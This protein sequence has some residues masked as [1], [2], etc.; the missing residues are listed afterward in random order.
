MKKLMTVMCVASAFAFSLT[1][2]NKGG[3]DSSKATLSNSADSAAYALG[4]T[5]GSGLKMNFEN[6]PEEVDIDMFLKGFNEGMK[7]KMED[8]YI[9]GAQVGSQFKSGL[10]KFPGGKLDYAL[11][12]KGLVH[13]LKDADV[14]MT[15]EEANEF[16]SAYVQK[17]E[18][19]EVADLVK[20]DEEYIEKLKADPEVKV[21]ESGLMYKITELGDGEKP[22][23]E[24]T[25]VCHYEGSQVNGEVFDSSYERDEPAT[26][27]LNG[28]IKGWTEGFQL[29]PVG[30]KFTLYIPGELAYGPRNAQSSRP[31]GLLIFK[32]EL[33]EIKKA[34]ESK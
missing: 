32:C 5:N 23:A 7:G 29:M 4:V 2:C 13:A 24:D 18:Q 11:V 22:T 28:V 19:E 16:I 6:S 27:P 8:I 25:V 30:S 34:S 21:T 1:S 17:A 33:L 9:Y 14:Q 12:A 15:S 31:S 3:I 20:A 26:F 10:E